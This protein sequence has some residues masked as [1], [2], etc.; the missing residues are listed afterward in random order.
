MIH[1][2]VPP[3]PSKLDLAGQ[4]FTKTITYAL[5]TIQ[6]KHLQSIIVFF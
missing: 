6:W 2:F 3:S 1:C 5:K 4:D